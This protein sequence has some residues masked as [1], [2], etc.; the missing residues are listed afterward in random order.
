MDT[1]TLLLGLVFSCIGFAYFLY[2][3]KQKQA[4][5]FACGIGLMLYPYFISHK[6][7]L[8]AIGVVLTLIPLVARF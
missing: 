2:G 6:L 3:R 7:G 8:L 4:L 5:P 1:A